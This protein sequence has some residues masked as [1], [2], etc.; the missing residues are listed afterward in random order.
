MREEN[1]LMS[2]TV[3]HRARECKRREGEKKEVGEREKGSLLAILVF[4]S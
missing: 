3:V 2:N 4:R 1:P